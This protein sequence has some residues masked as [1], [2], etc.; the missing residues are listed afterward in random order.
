[1]KPNTP[2]AY[3]WRQLE[4]LL[5]EPALEL[6]RKNYDERKHAYERAAKIR[7]ARRELANYQRMIVTKG[8]GTNAWIRLERKIA[9]RLKRIKTLESEDNVIDDVS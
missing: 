4:T 5:S 8:P 1:M 7:Q 9:S 2:I 3:L 6:L